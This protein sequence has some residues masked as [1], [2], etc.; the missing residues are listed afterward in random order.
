MSDVETAEIDLMNSL[1]EAHGTIDEMLISRLEDVNQVSGISHEIV[2]FVIHITE[3]EQPH[4]P[5]A[6]R[7]YMTVRRFADVDLDS[8]GGV[9][10]DSSKSGH[11]MVVLITNN[12]IKYMSESMNTQGVVGVQNQ[13]TDTISTDDRL[14]ISESIFETTGTGGVSKLN[15]SLQSSEQ[16]NLFEESLRP[17]NARMRN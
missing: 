13:Y 11:N 15:V 6:Y 10:V 7:K 17:K 16:L 3:D 5:S 14:R 4:F 2:A 1:P 12:Y 9:G 8:I